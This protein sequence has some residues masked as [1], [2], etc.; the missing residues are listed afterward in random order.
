VLQ[1]DSPALAA[2]R[3]TDFSYRPWYTAVIATGQTYVSPAYQRVAQPRLNVVSISAPVTNDQNQIVGIVV[4]Q[5]SLNHFQ[6]WLHDLKLDEGEVVS[7]LDQSGQVVAH[8]TNPTQATIVNRSLEV[9][10]QQALAGK[11]GV[12]E[13]TEQNVAD[14]KMVA[15]APVTGY[16]WGIVI[17]QPLSSAVASQSQTLTQFL[18]LEWSGAVWNFLILLSLLMIIHRLIQ[19]L[20]ADE[21]HKRSEFPMPSPVKPLVVTKRTVRRKKA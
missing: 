17:E 13:T 7:I 4:V 19:Y 11:S 21:I 3:G 8:P 2:V 1:A 14:R 5:V 18:R 20:F 16:T 10:V 12:I 15:Y 6:D 9:S